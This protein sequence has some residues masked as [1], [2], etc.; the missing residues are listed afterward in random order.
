[1]SKN[2]KRLMK[3]KHKSF[4]LPEELEHELDLYCGVHNIKSQSDLICEAIRYYIKPDIEDETLRLIGIKDMQVKLQKVIDAQQIIFNFLIF[5]Y[6]NNLC[7]HPEIPESLKNEASMSAK[8]RFDTF[9]NSF[10]ES[11]KND[12]PFFERIL[13]QYFSDE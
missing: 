3:R 6:K 1:M 10:Q 9:F 7:Y 2:S 12:V 8:S 11:L 13:H 4:R 5:M